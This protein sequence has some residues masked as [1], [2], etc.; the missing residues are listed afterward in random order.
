M[1]SRKRRSRVQR[2][3][4]RPARLHLENLEARLVPAG[5]FTPLTNLAPSG[6]GTMTLLPN[7]NV[8]IQGGGVTNAFYQLKPD[9]SGSYINGTWSQ[10]ASMSVNRLYFGSAMLNTDK[11]LVIGGEYA[12]GQTS[13]GASQGGFTGSAEIYDVA[14]N[15]WHGIAPS[16]FGQFGDDPV[17]VLPNGKVLEG[18]FGGPQTQI[19]DPVTNTYSPGA[20]KLHG[21]QTDEECWVKLPNGDILSYSIFASI[22]TGNSQAQYYDPTN[23]TWTDTGPVPVQL[24]SPALGYELGA[25]MLLPNGLVFQLGAN[26]NTALYDYQSNSWSLGPTIP[27][28]FGADDAPAAVLPDGHVIFTAD[29]GPISGTFSPPTEV[30]DYDPN[31]NTISVLTPP[32][33]GVLSGSPSFFDRMLMLPNGQLLFSDSTNQVYVY[34][35]GVA[36]PTAD[37]P[38]IT[39]IALK[40]GSTYT[41]VGTQLNGPSEGAA[42]GDDVEMMS[43]YPLV[44]LTDQNGLVTYGMTSNWSSE[45]VATGITPV[46]VDVTLPKNIA[47]GAYLL[48]V[49]GAGVN[50]N[51]VTG[52]AP[53]NTALFVE[54][55]NGADDITMQ[56]DSANN[57]NVQVLANGG[58]VGE[59]AKASFTN[60]FVVGD[61]NDDTLTIDDSNGDP[62]PTGGTLYYEGGTGNNT[63]IGP[64]RTTNPNDWQITGTDTGTLNNDV[65]FTNVSNLLGGSGPDTFTFQ[66]GGQMTGKVDGGPTGF[67]TIDFTQSGQGVPAGLQT[68][69]LH[70]F[71]DLLGAAPA[72][73]GTFD[74]I[75]FIK[76]AGTQLVVTTQ[77][78]PTGTTVGAPFGFVV[79]VEDGTGKV[80]PTFTGNLTTIIAPGTGPGGATLGGITTLPAVNGVATF[81]G[82]TLDK[83]GGSA[84]GTAYEL[85][86]STTGLNT[87]LTNPFDIAPNQPTQLVITTQPPGIVTAGQAFSFFVK[88]EDASGFVATNYNASLQVSL[89]NNPGSN[90]PIAFPVTMTNGVATI[91]VPAGKLIKVGLGYTFEV[92]DTSDPSTVNPAIT[93][94]INVIAGS[95]TQMIITAEPPGSLTAGTKFGLSAKAVDAYGNIDPTF[96]NGVSVAIENNPGGATLGGNGNVNGNKGIITFSGLSLDKVGS[97]YTLVLSSNGLSSVITTG[98]DINAGIAVQLAFSSS[99]EPPASI[100]AGNTFGV[101]VYAEDYLGNL[102]TNYNGNIVMALGDNPTGASLLGPLNEPANNGIAVFSGLSLTTADTNFPN[103]YALLASTSDGSLTPDKSSRFDVTALAATHLAVLTQPPS[104]VTAGIAFI[105]SFAGEDQYGNVDPTYNGTVT[106]GFAAGGNP[107]NTNLN[108]TLTQ[109][110]TNGIATFPDLSLTAAAFGYQLQ[111]TALVQSLLSTATT[112]AFSITA[113]AATQ[114]AITSQPSNVPVLA[115][116]TFAVSAEDKFGNVDPTFNSTVKAAIANNVAGASLGGTTALNA[117]NGVATF[118]DLTINKPGVGYSLKATSGGLTATTGTFNVTAHNASQLVVTTA[119]SPGVTAGNLFTVTI[120]AEDSGGFTDLTFTGQVTISLANNPGGGSLG[121]TLTLNA[122]KGV[123]TFSNLQLTVAANGYTLQAVSFGLPTVTTSPFNV[124]AGHATQLVVTTQPAGVVAGHNFSI[125]VSAEDAYFNVDST[126]TGN[127][128]LALSNNPGNTSLGGTLNA[129]AVKGVANF[130]NLRLNVAATGYTIQASA[131][132]VSAGTS[133]SFDVTAGTATQLAV[134]TQPS[135]VSAG[136]GFGFA[137]SA[138][139]ALGNVDQTFTGNVAV[140]LFANPGHSTLGGTLYAKAVQGV[141]TFSG[142][143]LNVA[144]PGYVLQAIY[145]GLAPVNTASFTVSAGQATNLVMVTQPPVSVTAGTGFGFVVEALDAFGNVDTSYSGPLTASIANNPG[146]STLGGNVNATISQGVATFSGLTL[147]IADPGYTLQASGNGV[148]SLTTS[149]ITVNAGKATKLVVTTQPPASVSAGSTITFAVAAEDSF[150]NVDPTFTNL[151]SASLSTNPTGATLNGTTTVTVNSGVASFTDLSVNKTGNGYILQASTSGLSSVKGTAFSVTPAKADHFVFVSEPPSSV[152]AGQGFG[153]VLDAVDPFGNIDTNFSG[154][155]AASLV[156]NPGGSTLGGNLGATINKGVVTFSG[157]VLNKVGIGYTLQASTTGVTPITTSALNVTAGADTRLVVTTQPSGVIAGQGFSMA[158]SA[159]DAFGNVDS[160]FTGTVSLALANDPGNTSLGGNLAVQ[161]SGGVALFSGLTLDVADPGYTLQASY[162]GLSSATTNPFTVTAGKATQLVIATQPPASV[163]AGSG[164][165]FTVYAEDSL[166]NIDQSFNGGVSVALSAN[167]GNSTLGGSLSATVSAGVATFSGLT[168]NVA[169]P[170]YT[171]QASS[172][173]LTPVTTGSITVDPGQATQLVFTTEPPASVLVT[174]GFGFVV[175][176]E[177]SQGNV[178]PTYSGSISV[179]LFN[180]PGNAHLSGNT[181]VNASQGVAVFTG[182][183]VD[184]AGTGDTLVADATGLA[185]ATSSGFNASF[186]VPTTT[187]SLT[188]TLGNANWYRSAVTVALSASDPVL[189][190]TGTFFKI[191]NAATFSPYTGPVQVTGDGQHT[192]SYYSVNQAGR[193]ETVETSSFQIDTTA[194]HT[195]SSTSGTRGNNGWF[196]SL[197][198]TLTATDATSGVASTYYTVN[199]GSPV[200]YTGPAALPDGNLSITYY[201]VDVAGNQETAH[202]LSAKVDSTAPVTMPNITGTSGLNGYYISSVKLTLS[203]ADNASGIAATYYKLGSATTY[204]LYRGTAINFTTQGT[205]LISYYSVDVA[206]NKE[207]VKTTTIKI[208][209][210]APPV[211]I[212]TATPATVL[213]NTVTVAGTS[214]ANVSINVV[215]LDSSGKSVTAATTTN[216]TGHWTVNLDATTLAQGI[217]TAQVTGTDLAGN[218][219]VVTRQTTKSSQVVMV[220]TQ[221]PISIRVGSR[222]PGLTVQLED[223]FGHNL[224]LANTSVTVAVPGA[225]FT[226]TTTITT[227]GSGRAI[228]SDLHFFSLGTYSLVFTASGLTTIQS[229]QF[230]VGSGSSYPFWN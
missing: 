93:N 117:V 135:G 225:N 64:D 51:N 187:A 14:T 153:F 197:N 156:N 45:G 186:S 88:A 194:P 113:G 128:S 4:P 126:F 169:D 98:I 58:V 79:K 205:H 82:L 190:V 89:F 19:Y 112:S 18:Y 177:D 218:A 145:S 224:A 32:D 65:Q 215:L 168:L 217:L 141:A 211:T 69:T 39:G 181:S 23:N 220:L 95:A 108:G 101:I 11:L 216:S 33:Q 90:P 155:V 46:S 105:T 10:L 121:G 161:A 9:A 36:P 151:V 119:P 62:V 179:Q 147:N 49:S 188:G 229:G 191:D 157:L 171:L 38:T 202:T 230:V 184:Q 182:L 13:G 77:P 118:T 137:V 28:G 100:Q 123:A 223:G 174:A 150:G 84:N 67:D 159:E 2:S 140:S 66:V 144:D 52:G 158:V 29:A 68:G 92:I 178:D 148:S 125:A 44:T 180:N 116:I 219:K 16:P 17:E 146:N 41:V 40:G 106:V 165:G 25:G 189:P 207:A 212:T 76:T 162:T 54:M 136:V 8:M 85:E 60:I 228:F 204:T 139:D 133:N 22:S 142:L 87:I 35:D 172:S 134:T 131:S 110:A 226:G 114:F 196:K 1:F 61:N 6:L 175:K 30:C 213:T 48:D 227:D 160:N 122:V 70:G 129:T 43:N 81:S 27:N 200:L 91:N 111:G 56:V 21:D 103:G 138:E 208:D 152:T 31:T 170:G 107:T 120:N 80:N 63:L 206:G 192:V 75:D 34:S 104:N 5:T 3:V 59:F 185:P 72:I 124:T 198:L 94:N 12:N 99:G 71:Q 176:A 222:M 199:G 149:A 26:Q 221:G 109:N 164:F 47:P 193:T 130:S 42:Y 78:P 143:T 210:V 214:Q 57:A 53:A 209:S 20:T 183:S 166:G 15:K 7:G 163:T 83:P 73:T 102:A 203:A 86:I 115:P 97:G 154:L 201:S 24:S 167:P 96:N 132:G 55:G 37:L 50:T 127:V 74:N 195:T 173:G